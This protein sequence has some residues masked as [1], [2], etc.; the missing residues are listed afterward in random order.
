MTVYVV[1]IAQGNALQLIA[2]LVRALDSRTG[3]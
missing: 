3:S 2:D 1:G